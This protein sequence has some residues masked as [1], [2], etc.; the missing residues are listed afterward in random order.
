MIFLRHPFPS[1]VNFDEIITFLAPIHLSE[2][3][4]CISQ[5]S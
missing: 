5:S 2:T 3:Y 4:T 1:L